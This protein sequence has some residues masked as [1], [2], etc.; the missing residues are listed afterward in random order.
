MLYLVVYLILNSS[1]CIFSIEPWE[2]FVNRFDLLIKDSYL[3]IQCNEKEIQ[4]ARS[5]TTYED[6][7]SNVQ[8]TNKDILFEH[9]I[10]KVQVI[11]FIKMYTKCPNE[12]VIFI[13]Y[14]SRVKPSLDEDGNGVGWPFIRTRYMKNIPTELN[15]FNKAE[16]NLILAA[17]EIKKLTSTIE[18]FLINIDFVNRPMRCRIRINGLHK[19]A[20]QSCEGKLMKSLF[21]PVCYYKVSLI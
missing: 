13:A 11:D 8:C 16:M 9:G 2:T 20:D 10:D 18:A 1:V 4:I 19:A 21:E 3:I 17:I 12:E 7:E 5:V 6:L 14:F 15:F